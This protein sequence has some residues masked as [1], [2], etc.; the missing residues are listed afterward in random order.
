MKKKAIYQGKNLSYQTFGSGPVVVLI[1]GFGEDGHVWQKQIGFLESSFNLIVP[2]L[3]GSGT[4]DLIEDMSMEGLA[5][6]VRFILEQE[7]VKRC[8]IIGHSMGG[9][10]T[11]AFAEK[12]FSLL[13]GFGLFH[14]TA[15]PDSEEKKLARKK[16]IQHIKEKGALSFLE[17]FVPDLYSSSTKTAQPSIVA[18]HLKETRYFTEAALIAY[19]Q[20][21][22][23]RSDRT[24]VLEQNKIA[25]LFVL[26]RNDTAIPFNDT[27]G[28]VSMPDISYIHILE[29]S[30]HM[31]M[32]EEPEL[33]NSI[34]ENFLL[35]TI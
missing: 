32:I 30:G 21:M 4:S 27:L 12:Y 8:S 9:Y 33:S 26:G 23:D 17:T 28:L 19:Y 25:V 1:H 5:E 15:L 13:S 7:G 22:M 14:S 10:V 20:S 29:N 3:P 6:G 31:G 16:G 18:S 24:H 34:I 11:L 35:K 2:H